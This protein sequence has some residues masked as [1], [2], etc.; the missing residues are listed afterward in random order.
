MKYNYLQSWQFWR[1]IR[2]LL[3]FQ[4]VRRVHW[5]RISVDRF[6]RG[7]RSF[8]FNSSD[9]D[10]LIFFQACPTLAINNG[11]HTYRVKLK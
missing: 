8:H 2:H 5:R 3:P 1:W 7:V 10:I 9:E 4:F 11:K 6:L